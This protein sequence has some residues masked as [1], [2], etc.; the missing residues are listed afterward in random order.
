MTVGNYSDQTPGMLANSERIIQTNRGDSPNWS[1]HVVFEKHSRI[2]EQTIPPCGE[3]RCIA[4]RSHRTRYEMEFE[5]EHRY[6]KPTIFYYFL[7]RYCMVRLSLSACDPECHGKSWS[8]SYIMKSRWKSL[9]GSPIL[10]LG[11]GNAGHLLR[12]LASPLKSTCLRHV[13]RKCGSLGRSGIADTCTAIHIPT[14]KKLAL[15][16]KGWFRQRFFSVFLSIIRA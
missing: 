8:R 6:Y 15:V 7:T 9:R 11:S 4:V 16:V 12:T 3:I 10:S 14:A 13:W 1:L 5:K 2:I